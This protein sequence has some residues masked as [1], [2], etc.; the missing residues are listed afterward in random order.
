VNICRICDW[1]DTGQGETEADYVW[2]GC[3]SP[4][5]LTAARENFREYGTMYL[6][7][8]VVRPVPIT[9]RERWLRRALVSAFERYARNTGEGRRAAV[10]DIR[11]LEEA[12]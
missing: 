2:R 1:T 7:D 12:L 10:A 4:Y 8:P 3:N 5:S 6:P 11:R 9:E